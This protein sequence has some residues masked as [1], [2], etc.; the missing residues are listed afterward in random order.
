VPAPAACRAA[1]PG[2]GRPPGGLKRIF[3]PVPAETRAPAPAGAPGR[4]RRRSQ[5]DL[6]DFFKDSIS[7]IR[8]FKDPFV[9]DTEEMAISA[10]GSWEAT[11]LSKFERAQATLRRHLKS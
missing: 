10:S 2:G 4:R 6:S 9:R 1:R 5:S 7:K 3:R 11:P 8:F